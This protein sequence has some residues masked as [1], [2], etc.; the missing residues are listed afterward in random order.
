MRCE[1]SFFQTLQ[2]NPSGYDFVLKTK[3]TAYYVK[4]LTIR[5]YR[6]TLYFDSPE[7]LRLIKAQ[8]RNRLVRIFSISSK[9]QYYP[10]DFQIPEHGSAM[11]AV[12][13]LL[14]NPVCEE[15]KGKNIEGGYEATGNGAEHFGVFVYTGSG[16]LETLGREA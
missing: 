9:L 8:S 16:F 7:L 10:L 2:W 5:K 1:R 3:D 11:K 14:L 15:M 6:S 13:V 12:K 4:Y